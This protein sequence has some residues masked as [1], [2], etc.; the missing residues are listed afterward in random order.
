MFA[1]TL[2]TMVVVMLIANAHEPNTIDVSWCVY[3]YV[4]NTCTRTSIVVN[5]VCLNGCFKV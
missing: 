5:L 3:V 2:L 1:Q 4:Q